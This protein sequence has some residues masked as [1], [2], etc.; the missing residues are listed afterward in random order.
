[1]LVFR[2]TE[3]VDLSNFSLRGLIRGE[4]TGLVSFWMRREFACR[5]EE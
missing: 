3:L 2:V 1:M 5:C 4:N